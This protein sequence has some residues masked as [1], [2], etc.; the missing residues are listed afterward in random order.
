[1]SG[2]LLQQDTLI[3]KVYT[4]S[5]IPTG[6]FTDD[7]AKFCIAENF[8]G[9]L[10]SASDRDRVRVK[11]MQKYWGS[12]MPHGSTGVLP[13]SNHVTKHVGATNRQ[14][15]SGLKQYT[16]AIAEELGS[17]NM[18]AGHNRRHN[19][20]GGP[21]VQGLCVSM[22]S[23]YEELQV[24]RACWVKEGE[25]VEGRCSP[26]A[27]TDDK[28]FARGSSERLHGGLDGR[29]TEAVLGVYSA[30]HTAHLLLPQLRFEEF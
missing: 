27:A 21:S 4:G 22:W 18:H 29:A 12:C 1:M 9:E 24:F 8:A 30:D 14:R 16:D 2:K 23:S 10:N 20:P 13:L 17:K 26:S 28:L 19:Y 6:F 3:G 7:L 11:V 25:E 15:N 5:V